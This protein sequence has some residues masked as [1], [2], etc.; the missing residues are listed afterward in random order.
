M[1]RTLTDESHIRR[2]LREPPRRWTPSP[3]ERVPFEQGADF[4]ELTARALRLAGVVPEPHAGLLALLRGCQPGVSTRLRHWERRG[5]S[6]RQ[7]AAIAHRPGL[8]YLQRMEW[9]GIARSVPL[10]DR[11]AQHILDRLNERTR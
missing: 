1:D 4:E 3:R 11:H 9:Y 6:F 2:R 7:L 5:A 10:S 8:S